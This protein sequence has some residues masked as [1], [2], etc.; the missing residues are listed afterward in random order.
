MLACVALILISLVYSAPA[1]AQKNK[2][3]GIWYNQEK[4]AKIEVYRT[5][6]NTF[7][8]KIVWL[9]EPTINGQPKLDVKNENEKLRSKP[10]IGLLI[11]RGFTQKSENTYDNGTIYDPKNGKTYSCTITYK[12]AQYLS[13]R[14]YIGI[15]L[16][17]RTS[18][19]TKTSL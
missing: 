14:G 19:W 7:A 16:L 17:G 12:D 6:D 5:K 11:L 13:I 4:T 8:G 1:N 10:I 18:V 2:V 3:E 15:S 9:K